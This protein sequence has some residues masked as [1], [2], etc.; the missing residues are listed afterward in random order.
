MRCRRPPARGSAPVERVLAVDLGRQ[1]SVVQLLEATV[2][3]YRRYPVLFFL[4]AFVVLAPFDVIVLAAGYGPLARFG[5]HDQ[6]IS[7]SILLARVGLVSSLIGALHVHAVSLA[8][9][10][11]RPRLRGVA[12]RGLGVLPVVVAVSLLMFLAE[13]VGLLLIVLPGVLLWLG[14]AVAPQVAAVEHAGVSKAMKRSRDLARGSYGHILMVGLVLAALDVG[15][16]QPARAI[17]LGSTSGITS[18][19][20]GIA[21]QTILSSFSA[22]VI[23]LL[24]F[25]LRARADRMSPA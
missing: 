5:R 23:A 24:Y 8:G 1:R 4:L 25:D 22:L 20:V 16:M 9:A 2:A 6:V 3:L 15:V 18:V 7:W 19:S 13:T 11:E 10:G 17:P 12:R 14:W 21:L